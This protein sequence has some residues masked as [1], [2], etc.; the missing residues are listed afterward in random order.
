MREVRIVPHD[1]RWANEF[2]REAKRLRAV[3]GEAALAIHHI[4]ST[5]VP[6]LAAK[7][8]VDVLPVVRDIGVV[9]ALIDA[10]AALGYTARGEFGLP[11][12]RYFMRDVDGSRT[13][14]VHVYEAGNPEVK[15]HLAFR[16]YMISHPE[17]ARAYG[18]LKEELARR[19][20]TDLEAY[21]DG[22]DAFVGEGERRALSWKRETGE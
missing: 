12:R 4:G 14:N 21:M 3:F 6:G 1:P 15:R 11:G 18:R 16:D 7:P 22:K 13:H 10:L 5:A 9:D 2:E 19:F 8:I 17:E 20:P